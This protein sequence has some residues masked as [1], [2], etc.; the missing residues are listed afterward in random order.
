MNKT[1]SIIFFLLVAI[2]CVAQD[3]LTVNASYD[4]RSHSIVVDINNTSSE[5]LYVIY[6]HNGVED[7]FVSYIGVSEHKKDTY[8]EFKDK[9][10][11]TKYNKDK[12][13]L[14][15][16]Y[17][18]TIPFSPHQSESFAVGLEGRKQFDGLKRLFVKVDIIIR[19]IVKNGERKL[20]S[21]KKSFEQY[22]D[23]E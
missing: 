22:I 18:I 16:E 1:L 10:P 8:T 13:E 14:I 23:I 7:F 9:F 12:G 17:P 2:N 11:L 6:S 3:D 19:V 21:F 5:T 20:G 15:R 4:S